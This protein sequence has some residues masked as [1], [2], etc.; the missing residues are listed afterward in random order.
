MRTPMDLVVFYGLAT[1]IYV[2]SSLLLGDCRNEESS[3]HQS[4]VETG[5][6]VFLPSGKAMFFSISQTMCRSFGVLLLLWRARGFPETGTKLASLVAVLLSVAIGSVTPPTTFA[7]ICN[8]EIISP[9]RAPVVATVYLLLTIGLLAAPMFM[10]PNQVAG[11][12]SVMNPFE[13]QNH[14]VAHGFFSS[15]LSPAERP[16]RLVS[17]CRVL[18]GSMLVRFLIET[19]VGCILAAMGSRQDAARDVPSFKQMVIIETLMEHSQPFILLLVVNVG[20][21]FQPFVERLRYGDTK[22]TPELDAATAQA[23]DDAIVDRVHAVAKP[24]RYMMRTYAECVMGNDLITILIDA[25]RASDRKEAIKIG[26]ALLDH[27]LV[28]QVDGHN[29]RFHDSDDAWYYMAHQDH[30]RHA[31]VMEKNEQAKKMKRGA[32]L[33][34][35]AFSARYIPSRRSFDE[36]EGEPS[37]S[38]A[39]MAASLQPMS[40]DP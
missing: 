12:W 18:A 5:S 33:L 4:Y 26:Q 3:I 32:S 19:M 25:G 35:S 28:T 21:E 11:T 40:S 31:E 36:A 13:D 39:L 29:D 8:L 22:K 15:G 23:H 10:S 24:R 17:T 14:Q 2:I 37:P 7:E 16:H 1:L 34:G 30:G 27:E 9:W 38:T 20:F 6:F